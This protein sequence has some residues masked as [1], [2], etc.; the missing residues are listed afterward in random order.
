MCDNC[1]CSDLGHGGPTHDHGP[2]HV[3]GLAHPETGLAL[4]DRLAER[5][6]GFFSAKRL[7]V[8]NLLSFSQSHAHALIECTQDHFG[9]RLT[10]LSSR[11]LAS[12]HA[13]HDH[14]HGHSHT[15]DTTA[16]HA[17]MDAHKIGHALSHLTFDGVDLVLIENGGS[18]AC[19]A[20]NDLGENARVA[21]FSVR[22]GER[23][24][25]KNPLLFRNVQ[26]VLI[27]ESEL[28]AETG[29]DLAHARA[30]LEQAAPGATVFEVSPLTGDGLGAW[31]AF[32]DEGV[33]RV[34]AG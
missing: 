28:L 14:P 24:P 30:N 8:V 16:E 15:R 13:D 22:E 23:K 17:F 7:F 5:N 29:F 26:A 9:R 4:A 34:K 3:H 11:L 10:V 32:L 21:V 31:M 33:K 20:V 2:G 1:G 25:L 27:T 6:R 18:A 19:Q 12:V